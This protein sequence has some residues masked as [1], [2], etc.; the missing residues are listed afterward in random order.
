MTPEYKGRTTYLW[1]DCPTCS[2]EE[3][4]KIL[5]PSKKGR[6]SLTGTCTECSEKHAVEPVGM[7]DLDTDDGDTDE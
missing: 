3:S 1:F 7:Y 2:V 4:I 6:Y 5:V